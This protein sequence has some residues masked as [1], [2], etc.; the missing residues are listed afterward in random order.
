MSFKLEPEYIDTLQS[1]IE[2]GKVGKHLQE[3]NEL[4]PADIAEIVDKLSF[5]EGK[6]L[7][8][9]LEEE[10][11]ADVLIELDEDL[12]AKILVDYTG[13][14]I[15]EEL[16]ENLDSDDAADLVG[17]LSE[18]KKKEVLNH[19]EDPKEAQELAQLLIYPED[20]AGALMATEMIKVNLNWTVVECVREMRKQAEEVDQV[21]SIYVVDDL[22]KLLG[23]LS[24]KKLLTIPTDSRIADVYDTKI[25]SVEASVDAEDVAYKMQKYDLFVMP[26]ID[27]LGNL[28]GRI[29]IDDVVDVIREEA[30][31]DYN[32]ASGLTDEVESDDNVLTITR[33]R[34]PWLLIGLFGGL[35][36]ASVIGM[37]EVDLGALPKMAF[38]IPLIAAMGGN[39][40]VQS[41]AIIV[42]SLAVKADMGNIVPRLVKELGV[43]LLNGTICGILIIGAGLFLNYGVE[44]SITVGLALLTVIIVSALV[45]TFVPLFLDKYKIDPALATGPFIT[46]MNDILGLFIY[47]SI[48]RLI[49]G[50]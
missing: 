35:L 11:A 15:A 37:Y 36:A 20:T 42:Q 40:G 28:I 2:S 7:I 3:L 16:V 13:K 9:E 46:T 8:H 45:G 24:L 34:L 48:G 39:V 33:A 47:F 12:R 38:F 31:E 4:H 41:S 22:G 29:T 26:V 18:E 27:T 14:E 19:I 43:A 21:H 44:L 23:T 17:E 30:K 32:L 25:K 10:R 49:L 50:A 1:D 6:A 5:N